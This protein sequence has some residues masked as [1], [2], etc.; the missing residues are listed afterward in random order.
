MCYLVRFSFNLNVSF[1]PPNVCPS[2]EYSSNRL[3]MSLR[4]C[5][6]LYEANE[7]NNKKENESDNE[8]PVIRGTARSHLREEM[9]GNVVRFDRLDPVHVRR[10]VCTVHTWMK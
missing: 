6:V 2:I 4:F 10:H 8:P 5:S 9:K 1:V 3:F 7:C